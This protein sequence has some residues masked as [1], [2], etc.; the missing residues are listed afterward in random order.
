MRALPDKLA[1]PQ[2][3]LSQNLAHDLP[4]QLLRP[5]ARGRVLPTPLLH[6]SLRGDVE[7][8]GPEGDVLRGHQ[9]RTDFA[10]VQ[11]D[12][13]DAERRDFQPECVGIR[14]HGGLGGVVLSGEQEGH[15]RD[16]RG[17][18]DYCRRREVRLR[19][20]DGRE[21]QRQERPRHVEQPEH[22]RVEHGAHAAG[23]CLDCWGLV[24]C[25]DFVS[26]NP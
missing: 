8:V 3:R 19:G 5:H 25:F 9:A 20:R 7:A 21:K 6:A 4:R 1:L 13:L 24:H 18:V 16:D 2:R 14:G 23:V 12:D 10:H 17:R 26:N 11:R 15:A 22:V